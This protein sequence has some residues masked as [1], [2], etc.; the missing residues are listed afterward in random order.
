MYPNGDFPSATASPSPSTTRENCTPTAISRQLQPEAR[1]SCTGPYCTPTAISR[2][3]QRKHLQPIHDS[4]VPQRRF[5]VSYSPVRPLRAVFRIVPQRRF[6]VSYSKTVGRNT[7]RIYCTPTAISRQLQLRCPPIPGDPI[8]PQRRFPVSYSQSDGASST[9]TIVPQRRFPV[10][11]S[12][13]S[14]GSTGT[15]YCTPTA[16]SRQLQHRRGADA[17]EADCTP[18]AISRQLQQK[19]DSL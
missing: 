6:P 17:G 4:I 7:Y 9:H 2:Q 15:R 18:T 8:V 14:G 5:P 13:R 10:S 12:I 3:L 1:R 11:Y 19:G 16:I